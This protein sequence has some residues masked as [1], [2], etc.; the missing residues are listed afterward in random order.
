MNTIKTKKKRTNTFGDC[1]YWLPMVNPTPIKQRF[2]KETYE[3]IEAMVQHGIDADYFTDSNKMKGV[4]P[5]CGKEHSIGKQNTNQSA[6]DFMK[7]LMLND[8]HAK[9]DHNCDLTGVQI[10][11]LNHINEVLEAWTDLPYEPSVFVDVV[12]K[13]IVYDIKNIKSNRQINTLVYNSA[14]N[15]FNNLFAGVHND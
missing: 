3:N 5:K 7:D 11:A 4:I 9:F 6:K 10:T 8:E 14:G 1:D 12:D 15:Q 2:M 13:L